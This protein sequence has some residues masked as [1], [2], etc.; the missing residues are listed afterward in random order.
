[1]TFQ[2]SSIWLVPMVV[3]ALVALAL[4]AEAET[5]FTT[6]GD[7]VE[8]AK[9][10]DTLP[11]SAGEMSVRWEN[12]NLT[13]TQY[14]DTPTAI[15]T[16]VDTGFDIVNISDSAGSDT[17]NVAQNSSAVSASEAP[18]NG[19]D[20]T[21]VN[22]STGDSVVHAFQVDNKSNN[23][24]M[25]PFRVSHDTNGITQSDSVTLELFYENGANQ[26]TNFDST[27]ATRIDDNDT[28]QLM[29]TQDEI[30]TVYAVQTIKS[31]A[32]NGDTVESQFTVS[33]QAPSSNGQTGTTGDQ[34]EDGHSLANGTVDDND[35]QTLWMKASVAGPVLDISKSLSSLAPQG[36]YRPGDTVEYTITVNNTGGDTAHNVIVS[37]AMP[38]STTYVGGSADN[39]NTMNGNPTPSTSFFAS[40]SDPEDG[41]STTSDDGTAEKVAWEIGTI[42]AEPAG[43]NNDTVELTF[44]VT[45]D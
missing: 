27:T 19:D 5:R 30:K 13:D 39:S 29:F 42:S 2:R 15:V 41:G 16:D 31:T 11:L 35:T 6:G 20:T 33:D 36:T 26:A 23:P 43:N 9:S 17:W 38:D 28:D 12:E 44:Q 14:A 18:A 1:M 7:T 40:T 10:A 32:Q 3:L 4:P 25:I 22:V 45:I 21:T 8:N 34:W 24:G 37:D